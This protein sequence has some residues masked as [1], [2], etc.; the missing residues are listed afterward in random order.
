MPASQTGKQS[1]RQPARSQQPA[2][3]VVRG[4]RDQSARQR[5]FPKHI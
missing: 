5:P 1:S 2:A 3:M 4:A